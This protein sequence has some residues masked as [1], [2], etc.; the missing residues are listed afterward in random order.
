MP[1]FGTRHI[2][3]PGIF[4]QGSEGMVR[5]VVRGFQIRV[6][7]VP[8]L[9]S[10][11]RFVRLSLCFSQFGSI[12]MM[13][14]VSMVTMMTM[15]TPAPSGNRKSR[16]RGRILNLS[17]GSRGS[18]LR[19]HGLLEPKP[20]AVINPGTLHPHHSLDLAIEMLI[21]SEFLIL[22]FLL[23]PDVTNLVFEFLQLVLEIGEALGALVRQKDD[24]LLETLVVVRGHL[25]FAV[26]VLDGLFV[27][28]RYVGDCTLGRSSLCLLLGRASRS[29]SLEGK[30]IALERRI[31]LVGGIIG[32]GRHLCVCS[33]SGL[34]VCF[35]SGFNHLA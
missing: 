18:I 16:R 8:C 13:S 24:A 5:G 30:A 25:V 31:S 12:S 1:D 33:G 21:I 23:R 4:W 7:F 19:E 20:C 6:G 9:K 15:V 27:L 11:G 35:S 29:G 26:N 3:S 22:P 32:S 17:L 10:L 34:C 28:F 14:M 2:L